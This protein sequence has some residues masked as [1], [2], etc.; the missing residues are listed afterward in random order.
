MFCNSVSFFENCQ[1][2]HVFPREQFLVLK[3]EEMA[4]NPQRGVQRIFE[5]LNLENYELNNTIK[6]NTGD[7]SAVEIDPITIT[8]L[9][10]LF[11][12]FTEQLGGLLNEDDEDPTWNKKNAW[13]EDEL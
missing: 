2:L 11:G 3:N 4:M 8:V 7:Y 1:W 9:K 10:K 5:H 13:D 6:A 12:P